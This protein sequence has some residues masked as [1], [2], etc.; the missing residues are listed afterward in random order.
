MQQQQQQTAF[1]Q[2]IATVSLVRK[3]LNRLESQIKQQN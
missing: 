1:Q 3:Q 2:S